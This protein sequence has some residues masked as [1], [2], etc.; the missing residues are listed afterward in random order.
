MRIPFQCYEVTMPVP[1]I[2][3]MLQ[4]KG[5]SYNSN[6][7][8]HKMTPSCPFRRRTLTSAETIRYPRKLLLLAISRSGVM[9]GF[10]IVGL[11][12]STRMHYEYFWGLEYVS[13]FL[14]FVRKYRKFELRWKIRSWNGPLII[15]LL[16]RYS[17]PRHY[18]TYILTNMRKI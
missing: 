9:Q 5:K 1:I 6:W 14:S 4:A 16:N 18:S 15:V 13:V 17:E 3:Y 12:F 10:E 2:S 11:I 8:V 7:K